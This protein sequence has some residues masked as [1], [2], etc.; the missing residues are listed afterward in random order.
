MNAKKLAVRVINMAGIVAAGALITGWERPRRRE[1]VAAERQRAAENLELERRARQAEQAAAE[2][3]SRIARD[4]H[5][6]I[7]QSLYM[8]SISLE[9]CAELAAKGERGLDQRLT[10]LSRLSKQALLDARHYI[11]DLRPLQEGRAS[12][13]QTVQRQVEEFQTVTGIPAEVV[14]TGS[15]SPL[16]LTAS[17][18]LYRIVQESLANVYKHADASCVE[19]HL[20]FQQGEVLLQVADDGKGFVIEGEHGGHGLS[21][22]S[23]RA[24][25]LGGRLD[26]ASGPGQ[27]TCVTLTLPSPMT[28]AKS[29]NG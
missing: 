12:L 15:E 13:S 29:G 25:E 9:A 8:L 16:P 5:D 27:G 4:I 3:R 11:F 24:R 1:A 19:V 18:G 20:A 10:S 23:E 21:N 28:A 17:M 2:E 7:A 26:I 22:L 14:V 6:G